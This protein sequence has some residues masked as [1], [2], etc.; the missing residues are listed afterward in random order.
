MPPAAK[1]RPHFGPG[2]LSAEDAAEL[3]DR[4][5]DAA[6]VLFTEQGFAGA[7]MDNIAKRAGA[8]TKTLYSRYANKAELL[9]AVVRRNVQSTVA[10]HLRSFA[11]RPEESDP[12]EFLFKFAMQV[13]MANLADETAGLVRVTFAEGHRFPVLTR[14]YREVTGRGVT[15]IAAA[16]RIWRE[17]GALRF[18][19]DPQLLARLCF[20][21]L[22]DSM[23]IRAILGDPMSRAELERY[24]GAGVDVFL[25]GIQPPATAQMKSKSR[26]KR[27]GA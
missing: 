4:L 20:G 3:P 13:G 21:M 5:L 14:M 27:A 2:R 7:S 9:E 10:D 23:R 11:L 25:Q 19:G 1:R 16:L 8:S 12:R 6:F 18:D 17:T 24:V 26:R 22:T 15:A